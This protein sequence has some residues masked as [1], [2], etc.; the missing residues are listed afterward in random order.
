MIIHITETVLALRCF[1][2]GI[3]TINRQLQPEAITARTEIVQDAML[4][5]GKIKGESKR[6]S[7]NLKKT[8][9]ES[10]AP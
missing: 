2:L 1:S 5:V 6:A 4:T 10:K 9:W 8:F 7:P 3:Q